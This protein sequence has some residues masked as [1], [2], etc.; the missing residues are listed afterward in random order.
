MTKYNDSL[1]GYAFNSDIGRTM[2]GSWVD[3]YYESLEFFYWEPQHLGKR[4]VVGSRIDSLGVAQKHWRNMEVTLNHIMKYFFSLSPA[5]VI[6]RTLSEGLGREIGK[7][8]TISSL[9]FDKVLTKSCQPDFLFLANSGVCSLEMKLDSK[10][11]INQVL[12][13]AL[14]GLAVEQQVGKE[15]SHGLVFLG[16]GKFEEIWPKS[17]GVICPD[18][19]RSELAS[20]AEA[21]SDKHL[22]SRDNRTR[23][24]LIVAGLDIGFLNYKDFAS[25]LSTEREAA[26]DCATGEMYGG[27]ID[28]LMGELKARKLIPES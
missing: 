19:L 5:S 13:Y 14:M 10:T 16:K 4:K 6:C 25:I 7:D 8:Y 27:L 9:R 18:S 21:F 22:K 24:L 12:K 17:S 26:H 3:R 11:S 2:E 1:R 23:Y 20:K 15:L 28:G